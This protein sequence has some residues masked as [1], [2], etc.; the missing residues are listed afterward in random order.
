VATVTADSAIHDRYQN[1]EFFGVTKVNVVTSFDDLTNRFSS[2]FEAFQWGL[3][4]SRKIKFLTDDLKDRCRFLEESEIKEITT[5]FFF[6]LGKASVHAPIRI[7]KGMSLEL[8]DKV[9]SFS[10]LIRDSGVFVY[11][12]KK[13]C[14]GTSKTVDRC[15]HIDFSGRVSICANAKIHPAKRNREH[16]G[17][18]ER[19][20]IIRRALRSKYVLHPG[21]MY[22]Y[23]GKFGA[24]KLSWLTPYYNIDGIDIIAKRK[25]TTEEVAYERKM[26][27]LNTL[28]FMHSISECLQFVHGRGWLHRDIKLEN[29]L[30]RFDEESLEIREVVLTDFAFAIQQKDLKEERR[31]KIEDLLGVYFKRNLAEVRSNNPL[32]S[33]LFVEDETI[34]PNTSEYKKNLEM[35]P[36][37]DPEAPMILKMLEK[38]DRYIS[39]G[40]KGYLAPEIISKRVFSIKT[41]L[42]ALGCS[43]KLLKQHLYE[44]S[45]FYPEIEPYFDGLVDSLLMEDPER[46]PS[47]EAV[48][49]RII[50]LYRA[51]RELDSLHSK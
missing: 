20:F 36:V 18:V 8:G 51:Q 23:E 15:V 19:E 6:L 40:T 39:L 27:P 50:G 38:A 7:R 32:F 34:L 3:E 45:S 31:R 2:F 11:S 17:M 22:A 43:F 9:S 25:T 14:Y 21:E 16:Y 41:D 24:P 29:C 13:I 47:I 35:R 44:A 46:R 49:D 4:S 37:V 1:L 10:Y 12:G 5:I 42:Y 28:R 26:L 33:S 30:A 48:L